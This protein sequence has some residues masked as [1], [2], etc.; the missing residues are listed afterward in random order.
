VAPRR[1]S[2]LCVPGWLLALGLFTLAS[3]A[4]AGCARTE[5][6]GRGPEVRF[7]VAADPANLNPLFAHADAGN[8]EQQLAHLAFE[9]F[10]DL[11]PSGQPVPEL[12]TEIPS[13]QNGGLSADGRTITYHLRPNVRW[14]DGF[15]LTAGDV[16]FTLHAIMDPRNPVASHE[17]YDLID[18]A[19]VLGPYTVRFHLSRAW[20][21]AVSTF[22]A[23]GTSPQYVLPQH[24]LAFQSP[25]DE[26]S[27]QITVSHFRGASQVRF[28][29]SRSAAIA[30]PGVFCNDSDR[31][32]PCCGFIDSCRARIKAVASGHIRRT[33][34]GNRC[35][36]GA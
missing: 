11:D 9:P 4:A 15:P 25:L 35:G 26:S 12:I 5:G 34:D 24:V 13:V 16:I 31:A 33:P 22:F 7:D 30:Y 23:Y 18:K 32:A 19:D 6:A 17:G 29:A 1:G 14:S 8:V 27:G 10:F 3:V 20:A 2:I 28:I 36:S 21:P